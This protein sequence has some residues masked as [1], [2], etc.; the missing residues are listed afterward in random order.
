[1]RA[2]ELLP[3]AL[4]EIDAL[5]RLGVRTLGAFAALP[6]GGVAR[7]FGL[8]GGR[9]RYLH[10]AL[11]ESEARDSGRRAAEE[12]SYNDRDVIIVLPGAE[13]KGD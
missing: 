5:K 10:L 9:R 1:M 7:R 13:P 6:P 4:D 8:K 11:S 2:I 12:M 3:D